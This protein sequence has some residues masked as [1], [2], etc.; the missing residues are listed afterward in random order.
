[1]PNAN[2]KLRLFDGRQKARAVYNQGEAEKFIFSTIVFNFLLTI[3]T[4][5]Y[6]RLFFQ[7]E[8]SFERDQLL[9][10]EALS[11]A[12]TFLTFWIYTSVAENAKVEAKRVLFFYFYFKI[13]YLALFALFAALFWAACLREYTGRASNPKDPFRVLVA[14]FPLLFV[15]A[16]KLSQ[17]ISYYFAS[18]MIE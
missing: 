9:V 7:L 13:I 18:K 4:I 10:L 8:K 3:Y 11:V 15:F 2:G 16:I 12:V 6:L 17:Q 5:V 14:C 1:M